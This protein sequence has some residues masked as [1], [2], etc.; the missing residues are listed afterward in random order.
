M[1]TIPQPQI[2][3]DYSK[4]GFRDEEQGVVTNL[5]PH[6]VEADPVKTAARP[7]VPTWRYLGDRAA[8]DVAY[9]ARFGTNEAPTPSL[10]PGGLWA[11]VLPT[12]ESSR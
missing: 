1:A 4:H 2:S 6:A 10:A 7:T 12:T 3:F 8:A 11:Y 9:C 5:E